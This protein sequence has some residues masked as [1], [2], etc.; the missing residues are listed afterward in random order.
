MAV[1][2]AA[3]G[4]KTAVNFHNKKNKLGT[5]QPPLGVLY[6]TAFLHTLEARH[7]SNG[8]AEV[9]KMA[10]IKDAELFELLATH[11]RDM[12]DQKFQVGAKFACSGSGKCCILC[13]HAAQGIYIYMPCTLA[14]AP[15]AWLVPASAG[16]AAA[17]R[18]DARDVPDR[19]C[20]FLSG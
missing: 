20:Q 6:D 7:I 3:V 13:S 1:V 9:L 17:S 15:G 16:T 19:P 14:S 5:Y 10:C 4:I 11:G 8:S 18:N 2:D 12:I